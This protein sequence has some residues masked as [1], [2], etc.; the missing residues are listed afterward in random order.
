M[1]QAGSA[2]GT[3]GLAR[4]ALD[5]MRQS[6]RGMAGKP[7]AADVAIADW[8]SELVTRLRGAGFEVDWAAQD[9]RRL[10]CRAVLQIEVATFALPT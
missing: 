10:D 2:D 1:V 5:E 7:V 6:V 3:S 4:Q 8:R 9:H